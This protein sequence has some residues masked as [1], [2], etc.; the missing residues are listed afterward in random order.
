ML[1]DPNAMV[2]DF[3]PMVCNLSAML[4]YGVVVENNLKLYWP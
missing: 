3:N 4:S 1:L 2:W